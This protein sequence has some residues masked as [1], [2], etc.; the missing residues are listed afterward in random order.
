M[1]DSKDSEPWRDEMLRE[2]K[3]LL[4]ALIEKQKALEGMNSV[5]PSNG[6]V[7]KGSTPRPHQALTGQQSS[8]SIRA[9]MLEGAQAPNINLSENN[10]VAKSDEADEVEEKEN[11]QLEQN[12]VGP[13][14]LIW[15]QSRMQ[16]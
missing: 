11:R 12:A 13:I 10:P 9:T 5:Q 4:D 7:F 2:A 1:S 8:R 3:A 6:G 16:H 14:W 15:K